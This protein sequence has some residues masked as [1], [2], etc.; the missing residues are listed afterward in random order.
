MIQLAVHNVK[1]LTEQPVGKLARTLMDRGY[2]FDYVSDA[3]LEQTRADGSGVAT[4]GGRYKILVVPATR[5]MPVATMKKLAAL[6]QSGATVVFQKL[7]E[8]VNGYGRLEQRR[9]EFKAAL[10]QLGNR[11]MVQPDI[12]AA[13]TAKKIAREAIADS[14]L[15]FIRRTTPAGHDY[16]FANL[17]AK[18]LD[19]WVE[20]GTAP[21][22]AA[23]LDPLTGANGAAA[24]RT[25]KN[26]GAEIYLQIA[27]G[28]SLLVRTSN[29]AV[30]S[31]GKPWRYT[32][33]AGAATPI[34]GQWS[35]AFTKGGPELP[36]ALETKELKSWTDLGGDEAKRFGGTAHYRVEFD[37]P[38][39]KADDWLLDLGEVRESARVRLNGHDV[40]TAWSIPFR[41]RVG[42]FLKPGKNVLEL[43]VT[44]LAA[45]RIRDMDKRGVKWKIMNE[46]NFVN[47]NYQPFD[48]SGWSIMPSG[49]LGPVTLVPMRAV[50][51]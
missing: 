42:E 14:G 6:A 34:T 5:R 1:W 13:L 41:V 37:A 38:T 11:A 33:S 15:S 7:P 29:A 35:I 47:I 26:G 50:K 30:R 44:N 10:A 31:A 18:P 46:I 8:D 2:S 28:E 51:L 43:D 39:T 27:P 49:L 40:T 19:G 45:N 24:L 20:L 32:E 48:A 21:R 12:P 4:A 22:A 36:P 9:A 17:T 16:F 3:Q 23:I 25:A